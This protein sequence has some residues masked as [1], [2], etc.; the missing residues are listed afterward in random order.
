MNKSLMLA[1]LAAFAASALA[2]SPAFADGHTEGAAPRH[3][4]DQASDKRGDAGGRGQ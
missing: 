1:P 4:E 3:E 2:L